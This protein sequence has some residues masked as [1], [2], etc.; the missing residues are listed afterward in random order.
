ML[1]N[2]VVR[3]FDDAVFVF[4]TKTHKSLFVDG[5]VADVVPIFLKHPSKQINESY[6]CKIHSSDKLKAKEEI[7]LVRKTVHN[8][9]CESENRNQL[10]V[11]SDAGVE[12]P[13]QRLLAYAV[14]KW[15]IINASI[16]LNY[17]C[18]LQCQCCYVGSFNKNGLQRSQLQ[19]IAKQLKKAGAVFILFTGGEILLRKDIF[20][21][22]NDFSRLG[23][24]LEVKSNGMLLTQS[25]IDKFASLNLLN[26]QISIYDT[27]DQYS[28][29]TERHYHFK[30]LAKNVQ[31]AVKQGI[32]VSLSVLVGKHNIND[33]DKY[34]DVLQKTGVV[35]IF[36]SPYITPQR[37]GAGK[38]KQFR[39][40]RKE[41]DEKFYPF[42]EKIDGFVIPK[43]YRNR[44]KNGPACYA[45][46]E[47]IAIDPD[48]TV[49]PCL[50]LRLP[51]GNLLQS[52]LESILKKRK[53]LLKPYTLEK[54]NKCWQ[55]N[56]TDYCDSCIGTSLLESGNFTE[57]S[58]HKCDITHFYHNAN[59]KRKEA[60]NESE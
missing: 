33:L 13:M 20:E 1:D 30:H 11:L 39:L 60:K 46:R 51:V 42:L 31:L 32:P 48:G 43:K 47:Q 19:T 44:C 35:E 25:A 52:D 18:N 2:L 8:F 4:D 56:I 24:V 26:L 50:D 21:I 3:N 16:E 59:L 36:Y 10:I 40:S 15:Q 23:F 12:T 7:E 41:M 37:N 34:H 38:E 6:L 27:E 54:I 49:F 58:Q 55:C 5:T 45:G 57:P 53:K 22:M 29:F 9:L 17:N 28:V 14:K